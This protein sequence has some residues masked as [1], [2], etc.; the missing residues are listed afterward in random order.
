VKIFSRFTGASSVLPS[1]L[2]AASILLGACSQTP[3]TVTLHSLQSSGNVSFVC[4]VSDGSPDDGTGLKLDECPDYENEHRRILGLVTQT[5]TNEVALVDLRG[6]T[7]VDLDPS[8]PGY[9]FLPV[10]GTPGAIVSTPGGVASFVGVSGLNKN[11][12]F[13]LPTMCLR[14][15][16]AAA[17]GGTIPAPRDLTSW[18]ACALTSAPGDMQLLVDPTMVNVPATADDPAKVVARAACGSTDPEMSPDAAQPQ[19]ECPADLTTEGGPFGRRKLLVAL[20]EEHKLVLLDAQKLL[21]RPPGQFGACTVEATY[22]LQATLPSTPPTPDLPD[23]LQATPNPAVCPATLYPPI[24]AT[25][26]TPAGMALSGS[27]LYVADHTLPV[28]HV[29]DVSDPCAAVEQTPLLPEAYLDPNRVVTTSRVAVSPLT[30]TGKQY[31]YAIDEKDQPT[32]SIMVFDVSAGTTSRTPVIFSG[33]PRQP[34]SPPDRIRFSA[35]VRDVSFVIRDFPEPDPTTGVGVFGVQCD[36]NP[37][38]SVTSPGA[39]Y[40]PTSDFTDGARPVN[41]RGVFGFAMLTNGQIPIIDVE[42]FDAP[43]RRPI[44]PNPTS[45]EDFRGCPPD[46]NPPMGFYTI[47]ETSTG[48]PTVTGESSC[49]VIEPN[50]AREEYLSISDSTVGLHAPTLTSLPQFSNPDPSAVLE[51]ADQPHML[52]VDLP[53]PTSGLPSPAQVNEGKP[54]PAQVNISGQFYA[55]CSAVNDPARD[56]MPPGTEKPPCDTAQALPNDPT[57]A[58]ENSLTLPLVE[59]RSYAANE[60]PTATFEGKI[61]PDRTSG[62]LAPQPDGSWWL[63]DPDAS[64]CNAGVEDSKAILVEAGELGIPSSSVAQWADAHADYVQIT[65]DFLPYTDAYWSRG[66]GRFCAD[67]IK[68]TTNDDDGFGACT[69][70]FGNIDEPTA[71]KATRELEILGAFTDHLVVGPRNGNSLDNVRCCFPSGT[72]YSV[73]ASKQ[74]FVNSAGGLHD[75]GAAADGSCVHTAS[76]DP[77]KQFFHSRAFEVCDS[78]VVDATPT[79]DSCLPTAANVGCVHPFSAPVGGVVTPNPVEP[80]KDASQCIF[81][82]LTSRFVIYRGKQPSGRDMT[83]SWATTGGFAPLAMSLTT[84]SNSVNPQAMSY[85]PELGYLAVIDGSTLGLS[86]FDLNSLGVVSPSPFY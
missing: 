51:P 81:E 8:T 70:E 16:T 58:I 52:A 80:G 43:C 19:R 54:F 55:A 83:F 1:A 86:L 15:P 39:L 44:Y 9:N 3:V 62:F 48:A 67:M 77:R 71:L 14:A 40:R 42:D 22:P 57:A 60:A 4:Q 75:I 18:A 37:T 20:P 61:M 11:G 24:T 73:R 38:A 26:P 34:Y 47:D 56:T 41:L 45:V 46:V 82:N 72:S 53:N 36:P 78:N 7:V 74:W 31:V 49:N 12:V 64:F 10:G 69:T 17:P 85:I 59:P 29:L 13:A 28:V 30:P 6:A 50:R 23:D 32:A 5:A 35:P 63:Q 68:G 65:G 79:A 66:A 21:D 27:Q 76:C 25:A 84:V 33:A 2:G